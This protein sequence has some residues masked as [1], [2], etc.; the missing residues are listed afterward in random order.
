[1]TAHQ[2][3][4]ALLRWFPENR[5][6]VVPRVSWGLHFDEIDFLALSQKGYAHG[7]EIKVSISDLGREFKK[8]A[9]QNEE[10][11]RN[12]A[13]I[14]TQKEAWLKCEW[15]ALPTSLIAKAEPLI[16]SRFGILG[17]DDEVGKYGRQVHEIRRAPKNPHAQPWPYEKRYLLS[18]NLSL[19]YWALVRKQEKT[20]TAT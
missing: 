13:G 1:M 10:F 12:R 19:K 2:I 8:R 7:V 18:R 9:Y 15:F 4:I 14:V 11:Y 3:E 5:W 20:V 16:P 17:I 6:L